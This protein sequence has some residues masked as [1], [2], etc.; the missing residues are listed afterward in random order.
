MDTNGHLDWLSVTFSRDVDVTDLLPPSLAGYGF[1]QPNPG[2]LGY[3]IMV[4]NE[5]GATLLLEGTERMGQHLIL[6]ASTLDEIRERQVSDQSLLRHLRAKEGRLSRLDVAV[7][8]LGSS[9]TR[10]TL[11]TAYEKGECKTLARAAIVIKDLHTPEGTFYIGKRSSDRFFRA[12]D[13]GA[14][15]GISEAWLR[16]ELECKRVVSRALGETMVNND[17]TRAVINKAISQF[18]DFPTVPDYGL[19]LADRNATI[20]PIPR[21]MT[22]TMRWLIEQ[23]APAAA[24][25]DLEHPGDNVQTTFIAIWNM[26]KRELT[27]D[28][29]SE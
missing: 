24:R 29:G 21:K 11:V 15:L 19:A 20:P 14:Q 23:V 16:L 7:D 28:D 27:G 9:L 22:N 17:N 13:K 25:Y 5:L 1:G 18:A 4:R 2:T 10:D 6:P 3:R 12:Y 8:I 26:R